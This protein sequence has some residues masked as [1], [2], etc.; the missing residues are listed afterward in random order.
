MAKKKKT[1]VQPTAGGRYMCPDCPLGFR[2]KEN[3]DQHRSLG[4]KPEK[5]NGPTFS[6]HVEEET[7]EAPQE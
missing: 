6:D 7:E 1:E 4:C 5:V 2:H 3:F